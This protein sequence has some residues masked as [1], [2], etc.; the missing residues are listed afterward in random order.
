MAALNKDRNT[1]VKMG[2]LAS[3]PVAASVKIYAGSLV[4]INGDGFAR[5]AVDTAG[6]KF[7]GVSQEY[8][9]NSGGANGDVRV[10]VMRDGVCDFAATGMGDDDVDKPVFILDDQTVG[11]SS[12]NGVGCGI[13]SE[14]ESATKVWIDIAPANTRTGK[15]QADSTAVDVAG[16]KD[17]LNSLLAKLRAARLIGS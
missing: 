13:I 15:A 17:D 5:P 3:F 11:L 2:V 10:K 4:C 12:N 8:V 16:L 9:D 1:T 7:V 6:L 14:V